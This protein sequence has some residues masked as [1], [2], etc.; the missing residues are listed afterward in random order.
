MNQLENFIKKNMFWVV[1]VSIISFGLVVNI[2][3]IV[4]E[5]EPRSWTELQNVLTNKQKG[6]ATK[7]EVNNKQIVI[8]SVDDV[9]P[10][11]SKIAPGFYDLKVRYK[12]KEESNLEGTSKT[13]IYETV[14]Q[15]NW[16]EIVKLILTQSKDAITNTSYSGVMTNESILKGNRTYA[17]NYGLST[18]LK[19]FN[20]A[21]TFSFLYYLFYLFNKTKNQLVDNLSPNQSKGGSQKK[22]F[23]KPPFTFAD[24]AGAEEEKEE[25]EELVDFLK[26][27]QKYSLMGARMPKGILLAGPPGTGKT[28]LAKAVAGE[29][30][31]P[32][33]AV[34]GS[35]FVEMFVGLGASRIR[36][37]FKTSQRYAPCI[38]FIDE[39]ETV[40]RKR[41]MS[42]GNTEQEQT[43]NQLLIELDGFNPSRGVLVIAATNE[44]DFL[45]PAL[46]RPG[47]FDRRFNIN[48]PNVKDR[49][50]ILKLHAQN[51]R[52]APD[53]DLK[54]IAKE[55]PGFSGAQLEGVLNE[56]ALLSIRNNLV[57]IDKQTLSE[58]VD[59]IL[60]GPSKKSAKYTKKE[61][62]MVSYHEAGHAVIGLKLPYAQKVQKITIIPRGM[63]GGYNIMLNE[64]E[65]FTSSKKQLLA[66]I[67]SF[68]GGRAA[69]ELFLDDISDGAYQDLQVATRI[70]TQMVT[71]F[72]MSDLG[73]VQFGSDEN[74]FHKNFSDAKASEIDEAVKKII[75][76]CYETAKKIISE[77]KELLFKI[78]DYLLELETLSKKD[79]E[80]ILTTGKISSSSQEET[81]ETEK[82]NST[83][84]DS[85]EI[86]D[87][88]ENIN[89]S[90]DS[91]DESE[92]Q[93]TEQI[94][95]TNDDSQEVKDVEENI[96]DIIGKK[97]NNQ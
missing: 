62:K 30:K 74:S 51:K 1:I 11:I 33:F 42:F 91:N 88:D 64:E 44:P 15:H 94:N 12:I 97:E 41:G 6:Q 4:T 79:I 75:S 63:A 7:I 26:N 70:A 19:S 90:N 10:Y 48:L 89:D 69:E 50:A 93:N 55:T 23:K 32:F 82:V 25:M 2:Y 67:T 56:A 13:I 77:N 68:L 72:G 84:D 65:T 49:E 73:L 31:V 40:A 52:I 14:P 60:M 34:S 59:R 83:N 61:K 85:K 66:T 17:N 96:N 86:K 71:K 9:K 35:E 53:V 16:D 46:L 47:R 78:S 58:A 81:Q 18:L 57:A 37:L 3:E 24:V 20:L 80:E 22:I 8:L 43:L 5:P 87:I 76:E 21:L 54:E 29:A 27:P 95:S 92:S 36:N 38:I 28:L 39:I 45:D